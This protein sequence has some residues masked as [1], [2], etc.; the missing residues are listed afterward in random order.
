M[1]AFICV[2]YLSHD[3]N[4]NDL[5]L[6]RKELSKQRAK[7][8]FDLITK[9]SELSTKELKKLS[10]ERNKQIRYEN[11]IWR[12][13]ASKCTDQLGHGN[14]RINPSSVNWQ[15]ESDI[16]WLYGP[17]Y[18]SPESTHSTLTKKQIKPSVELKSV[19]KHSKM[20]TEK[21]MLRKDYWSS[22]NRYWSKCASESG[23]PTVQF[24]PNIVE[25]SYVPDT[26]IKQPMKDTAKDRYTPTY[27]DDEEEL[28]DVLSNVG[29]YLK[30]MVFTTVTS[31]HTKLYKP[32]RVTPNAKAT[33]AASSIYHSTVSFTSWLLYTGANT[34][35]NRGFGTSTNNTNN[36]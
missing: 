34:I 1:K 22:N 33:A 9:Q 14:E 27:D 30:T 13:M 5:I 18:V 36:L 6:A 23:K 32:I 4:S 20:D 16:T 25:V 8:T 26:P 29:N 7:T 17:L 19:L 31:N 35:I 15:K 2:D 10:A 3:W 12:Q 11:A 28:W 21:E 24:D